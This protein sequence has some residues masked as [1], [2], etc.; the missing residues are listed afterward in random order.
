MTESRLVDYLDHMLEAARLACSYVESMS[1]ENFLADKRTQ[2]AVILNM[3][4]LGESATKLLKDRPSFPDQYPDIPWKSIKGMRNR[5]AHGYFDID[6][7]IVWDTVRTSVPQ[8]LEH[9]PQIRQAVA[10]HRG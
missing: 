5:I 4:V 3:I 2:Q 9:L 1:K 6:L 7:D 10:G 8:L